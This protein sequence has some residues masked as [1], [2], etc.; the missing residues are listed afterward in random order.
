MTV[1][2]PARTDA[3]V[4]RAPLQV[5]AKRNASDCVVEIELVDPQGAHLPAWKPGAHLEIHL[6]SGLNR[7]YSLCS[8]PAEAGT[9]RLG[10]LND[11]NSRGGSREV[12][13]LLRGGRHR[14]R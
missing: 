12:H 3:L 2:S 5:R 4:Y 8:S 9:Y 13:E 7:Q 6:P 10:I 1:E 14:W 11:P